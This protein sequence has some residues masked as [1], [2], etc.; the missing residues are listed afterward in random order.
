MECTELKNKYEI[1]IKNLE[2]LKLDVI[3]FTET[4]KKETVDWKR[5]MNSFI[6]IVECLKRG[7]QRFL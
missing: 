6:F 3:A 7:E 2:E 1:I 4:K 5:L